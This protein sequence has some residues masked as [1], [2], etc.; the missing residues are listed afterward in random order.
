VTRGIRLTALL[1]VALVGAGVSYGAWSNVEWSGTV[2]FVLTAGF[3]AIAG[4]YI[5]LQARLHRTLGAPAGDAPDGTAEHDDDLYLPHASIWPF[6]LGTGT[7]LTLL[8]FVLGR[9]VL[10]FGLAVTAH[11]LVGWIGQSRRRD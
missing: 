6:E 5:A 10:V 9:V 1:V 7:T 3:V 2:L 8:G 11:A 4:G